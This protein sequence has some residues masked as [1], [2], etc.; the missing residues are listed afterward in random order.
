MMPADVEATRRALRDWYRLRRSAYPW[1]TAE[2]P[3]AILVSEFMLQQ[4][5]ASRVVPAYERFL[6]RFPTVAALAA[7]PRSDVVAEWRGLGYNRRAVALSQAARAVVERHGGSVPGDV[8]RLRS[9]PGVG[10]YTA[11][12]VASIGFG[13]AVPAIDV[14]VAR[15]VRRVAAGSDAVDPATTERLAVTLL[16]RGRPGAWNQAVMDVGRSFCRPRPRCDGCPLHDECRF[17]RTNATPV[18]R[19]RGA[20]AFEGSM[21]QLR[22]AVVRE[23]TTRP[24]ATIGALV[25]ATNH[26]PERVVRAVVALVADGVAAAGP[27]ALEGSARGRVRLAR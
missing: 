26:D 2:D 12:A 8:A 18:F 25:A 21:R 1:R 10:P 20:T 3:Y 6:A 13:V 16:D 27:A 11:A 24:S 7:A 17:A 4:T 19:R 5:Q 14:N 9:L 15:V 22:G 23:L